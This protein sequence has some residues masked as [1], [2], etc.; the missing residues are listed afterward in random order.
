MPKKNKKKSWK[1]RQRERQIKQQRAQETYRIQRE[2]EAERKPRQWPKGKILGAI[3][4]IAIIFGSYGAWQ[5]TRFST[6][7]E[8]PPPINPTNPLQ[9]PY[10]FTMKDIDGTQFSL[11]GF[12]GRII[13]I[14]VMGVGCHGQIYP[15][16]E[17]QLTQLK[18]VC[19]SYCGNKPVTLITVAVATCENSEL[20]QIR[21]TY[22]VAW[23]FGND[24]DDGVMDVAQKYATQGDGT[25]VLIDKTFHIFDSYSTIAASTLSSNI[26]Q[27]LGA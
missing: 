22:G 21:A 4:L 20:E 17:N 24:Y 2:R 18:T 26:N 5:Y 13:V 3:C 10:E 7:S 27:L 12:S 9:T 15:I 19:S 16:N 6:I 1:E 23:L 25:I 14:H 8:E 11:N